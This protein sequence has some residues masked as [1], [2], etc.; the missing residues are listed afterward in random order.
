MSEILDKIRTTLAAEESGQ[1]LEAGNRYN[2]DFSYFSFHQDRLDYLFS[3]LQSYYK[4]GD[5][6]LDIGSLFGYNCLG[7][8]LIGYQA[9]GTD[10]P[11]Y[12][13]A[14]APRFQRHNIDNRAA[15]L[16]NDAIPFPD[17]SCDIILASEILEHFNFHPGSFL[18]EAARVLRPGGKLIITTPNLIRLNNVLKMILGRSINWDIKD[19]YWDGAHRREFTAAEIKTLLQDQGLQTEQVIYRNFDYPNISWLVKIINWLLGFIFPSRR[20]NLVVIAGKKF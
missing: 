18:A 8:Q 16:K 9:C 19:S 13:T 3:L 12:V 20:G 14:F 5:R 11:K 2:E 17:E 7:A 15:D 10:L 1:E 6:F 4:P